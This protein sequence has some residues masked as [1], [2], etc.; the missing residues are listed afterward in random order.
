MIKPDFA[1]V[2]ISCA[3]P[4]CDHGGRVQRHHKGHEKLFL[5]AFKDRK[6]SKTYKIMLRRYEQFRPD[7]TVPLCPDHHAEIHYEYRD[8][9]ALFQAQQGMHRRDFSWD[10][11]LTLMAELRY[12]CDEWLKEESSGMDPALVF[13]VL[14]QRIHNE[15]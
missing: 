3:K 4:N 6:E 11:A 7:D 14:P 5:R 9:I 8:I 10:A 15:D 2:R 12:H 1:K 13:Q